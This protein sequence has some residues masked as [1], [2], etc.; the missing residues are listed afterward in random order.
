MFFFKTDNKAPKSRVIAIDTRKPAPA[1]WKEIVPQSAETLVAVNLINNQLVLDYLKDAQTQI[2][3][4]DLN[5]KL[6]REVA[7]PGI[8]SAG[9]FAGKRGDTETFYRTSF[10]TPATILTATT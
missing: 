6:V 3:I 2:K 9:G 4:V 1:D 5:G 8:G 10:T 7:L